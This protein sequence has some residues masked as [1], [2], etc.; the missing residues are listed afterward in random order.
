MIN[1]D[2]PVV[3][4]ADENYFPLVA[5]AVQSIIDNASKDRTYRIYVLC[6][7]VAQASRQLLEQ[8]LAV[9]ANFSVAYIEAMPY[10][11]AYHFDNL[12]YSIAAYFR[13]LIP[14]LF[15]QYEKV[16]YLDCDV[17]CLGD[18][19]ELLAE[20]VDGYM[21]GCVRDYG[22][23]STGEG[24]AK[25]LGLKSHL[26]YFNSGVLVFNSPLF[27]ECIT[28]EALLQRAGEQHWPYADQCL[29]NVVCE[30]KV[31]FLPM[32]WNV[33]S[34][35]VLRNVPPILG[36][37]FSQA[38]REAR[39]L[40]YVWD[41]PWHDFFISDRNRH[42]WLYAQRTPFAAIVFSRLKDAKIKKQSVSPGMVYEELDSNPHFGFCFLIKSTF[43]WIRRKFHRK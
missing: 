39:I 26:N 6:D 31:W 3:F 8:Q 25:A 2:I 36:E 40:H 12:T 43:L 13:L 10:L 22:M 15:H 20:P 14:F 30:G 23:M 28:L 11:M 4:C 16:I 17:I 34:D 33:M 27:R 18:I 42:F 7:S 19:A 32:K 38:K 41:K 1:K 24:E 37:E 29:L 21:L 35:H 5:T 9:V